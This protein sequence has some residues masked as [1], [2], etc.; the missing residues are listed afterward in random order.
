MYKVA[1][2]QHDRAAKQAA[3]MRD[4]AIAV[5]MKRK[6]EY[7]GARVPKA[8]KER[9]MARANELGMPISILIR[10]VLEDAFGADVSAE[11]GVAEPDA[12][13]GQSASRDYEDVIGWKEVEL[14]R[15]R[16]C[17]GCG[18]PIKARNLA[19]M[20][21]TQSDNNFVI[22]CAACKDQLS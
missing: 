16:V 9:I 22:L 6:E 12:S 4:H 18:E 11:V 1:K 17:D 21:F 15:E 2:N 3:A 13:V 19:T 20:G 5:A 10:R 14:H 8:L 7:L